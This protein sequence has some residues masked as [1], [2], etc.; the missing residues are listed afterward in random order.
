MIRKKVE[1]THEEAKRAFEKELNELEELKDAD[2]AD[3]DKRYTD[4]R[5]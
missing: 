4:L 2:I 3:L 5:K 1:Q